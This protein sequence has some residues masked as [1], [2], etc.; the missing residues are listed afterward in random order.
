MLY[1]EQPSQLDRIPHGVGAREVWVP[2]GSPGSAR[3]D[4]LASR[5]TSAPV[6][7]QVF[8]ATIGA[9]LAFLVENGIEAKLL[10][11]FWTMARGM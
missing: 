11:G 7:S 3:T 4:A 9:S 1:R 5:R 2:K 10:C 8:C 6:L